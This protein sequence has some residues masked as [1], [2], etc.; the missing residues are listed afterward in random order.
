MTSSTVTRKTTV[1]TKQLNAKDIVELYCASK[2]IDPNTVA[3]KAVFVV[4]G[5]GDWSNQTIDLNEHPIRL[6]I[7]SE[8]I[9]TLA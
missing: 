7:I 3:C 8:E 1:T 2:G 6:T 5:G 4:P 9:L